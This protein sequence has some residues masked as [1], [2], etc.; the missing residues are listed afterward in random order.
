MAFVIRYTGKS[1]RKSY[2]TSSGSFKKDINGKGVLVFNGTKSAQNY[3]VKS[4]SKQVKDKILS[5]HSKENFD[6]VDANDSENSFPLRLDSKSYQSLD[7]IEVFPTTINDMSEQL[8]ANKDHTL[9]LDLEFFQDYRDEHQ[10]EQH[11]A[12]IA[13]MVLGDAYSSFN[14]YIFDPDRMSAT[15]QLNYLKSKDVAY[16]VAST[17]SADIVMRLVK[18][19]LE[20]HEIN[21]IVSWGNSFDFKTLKDEGYLQLFSNMYALDVEKVLATANGN[22]ADKDGN[23][24]MSLKAVCSLLNITNEGKWHDALDDVKMINKVCNL[25][26]NNLAKPA[27]ETAKE[28]N[29]DT[30]DDKTQTADDLLPLALFTDNSKPERKRGEHSLEKIN[31]YLD[32][33]LGN[34]IDSDQDES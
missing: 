33:V 17:S 8:R 31:H 14:H 20:I 19:F 34:L 27:S 6:I 28:V 10:G 18:E 21:T 23:I 4:F 13:G 2:L 7:P 12:Q 32:D 30:I 5:S 25:Y 24:S 26:M 15:D 11:M 16:S 22:T 3:F 1:G 29:K 9:I